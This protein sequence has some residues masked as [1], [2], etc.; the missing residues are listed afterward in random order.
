MRFG[1]VRPVV[2]GDP[3]NS[4]KVFHY[5]ASHIDRPDLIFYSYRLCLL[6]ELLLSMANK[7]AAQHTASGVACRYHYLYEIQ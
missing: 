6:L 4:R 3:A 1:L 5:S 7:G 2:V